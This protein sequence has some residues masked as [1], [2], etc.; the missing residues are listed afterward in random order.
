MNSWNKVGIPITYPFK[1]IL[2]MTSKQVQIS[3]TLQGFITYHLPN[4]KSITQYDFF[5]DHPEVYEWV[6]FLNKLIQYLD[7][8]LQVNNKK[9]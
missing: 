8:F 4:L 1:L 9:Y 7:I 6:F 5:K 2:L 3:L